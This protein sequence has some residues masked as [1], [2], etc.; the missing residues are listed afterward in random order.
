MAFGQVEATATVF[1]SDKFY[2]EAH[3]PVVQPR[4]ALVNA[5]VGI[6][7]AGTG[8]EF[9]LW[10][11]HLTNRAVLYASNILAAGDSV[12]H[13]PPRTYGVEAIYKF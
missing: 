13:A 1:H 9:R 11:K 8:F 7:P 2:L 10:G 6:K 5:S 12:S 4:Y 3:N